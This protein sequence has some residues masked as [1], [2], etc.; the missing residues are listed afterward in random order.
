VSNEQLINML[1]TDQKKVGPR[2]ELG[3]HFW[4]AAPEDAPD[5]IDISTWSLE[6]VQQWLAQIG[7]SAPCG[8]HEAF[9]RH[10]I[11]GPVLLMLTEDVLKEELGITVYGQRKLILLARDWLAQR[12]HKSIDQQEKDTDS[13]NR[14]A[15]DARGYQLSGLNSEECVRTE[16]NSQYHEYDHHQ[17]HVDRNQHQHRK[18][19]GHAPLTPKSAT[20]RI[21][22]AGGNLTSNHVSLL[23]FGILSTGSTCVL[24]LTAL[25][26]LRASTAADDSLKDQPNPW[27]LFCVL[28]APLFHFWMYAVEKI[29]ET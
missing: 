8:C 26:S 29:T 5:K 12:W 1:Q 6:D 4:Q 3:R 17:P 9:R 19:H 22:S 28:A 2:N 13:E 21:H 25:F 20:R 16:N 23:R 11:T 7:L 27:I 15:D 10:H 14:D 18:G 24:A